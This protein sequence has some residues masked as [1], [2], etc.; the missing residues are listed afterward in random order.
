MPDGKWSMGLLGKGT[1]NSSYGHTR[2]GVRWMSG[3]NQVREKNKNL[4]ERKTRGKTKEKA[5]NGMS[6]VLD[7]AIAGSCEA[8]VRIR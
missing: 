7:K 8:G 1:G 3:N 2:E 4:H 5:R 6:L